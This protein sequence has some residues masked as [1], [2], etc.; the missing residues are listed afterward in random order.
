[1][2]WRNYETKIFLLY[3]KSILGF[4]QWF[5]TLSAYWNHMSAL[6]AFQDQGPLPKSINSDSGGG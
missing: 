3:F 1:M 2:G 6:K 4:E 5:S